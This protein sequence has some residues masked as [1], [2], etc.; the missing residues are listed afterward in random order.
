MLVQRD[1]H[2]SVLNDQY[3]QKFFLKKG[4]QEDEAGKL[5]ADD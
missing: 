3:Q 2:R 1:K 5:A 4:Y